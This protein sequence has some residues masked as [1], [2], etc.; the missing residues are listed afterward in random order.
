M[1]GEEV[2]NVPS[3]DLPIEPLS[4]EAI[5]KTTN[6][7]VN[8]IEEEFRRGF[9]FIQKH[10]RSVTFWGSARFKEGN[11]HYEQARRLGKRIVEELDYSVVTGGGPGIMEAGNRGAYEGGGKSLGLTIKLPM[12]QR[13]NA[14]VT[15]SCDFYYFFSRKV[16]LAFA[17]EAYL[18]FPGGFGTLD[19]LFEI[20]TL[21]QTGKIEGK[22]PI[23]LIGSD[24]WKPL[25]AFI[26]KELLKDHSAI[27]PEDLN[28]YT[29][30]DDED[31][32]MEII[33]NAPIRH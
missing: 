11:E 15:D 8:D 13:T 14:Y 7:R 18:Y 19:E 28:L 20:L 6:E 3:G 16:T 17:A 25:D 27:S 9:A 24:Y 29:I 22:I 10:P 32:I 30:T 21:V 33:K 5:E 12:E 26:R 1:N 31:E 4:R 2:M 23:I